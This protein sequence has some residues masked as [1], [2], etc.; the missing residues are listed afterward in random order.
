MALIKSYHNQQFDITIPDC[1]WK[2]ALDNGIQGGKEKLNVM[3]FCFKNKEA[4][5]ENR[6]QYSGFMF[7]FTPDLAS[8]SNFI[9]QAYT[10]AKT[11]PE[12][13]GAVDA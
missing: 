12:F 3:M 1:Y 6:N 9:A 7:Q 13:E 2:V 8:E 5:D 4:A 11:L 10:H